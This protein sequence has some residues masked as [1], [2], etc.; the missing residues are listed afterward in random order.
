MTKELFKKNTEKRENITFN[1]TGSLL[2]A[3]KMSPFKLSNSEQIE[4]N[5][6]K[7]YILL[8]QL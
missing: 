2:K 3:L 5:Y 4:I 7:K 6:L 1:F 8:C